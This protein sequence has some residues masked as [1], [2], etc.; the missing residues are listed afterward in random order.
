MR[1]PFHRFPFVIALAVSAAAADVDVS[2]LPPVAARTV[3]FGKDIAPIFEKNCV[4]CHGAEKQKGGL[5][6]DVKDSALNGGDNF[7][8][9]IRPGKSAESPLVHFVAGL[10]PDVKM[11]SKGDP[12]TPEQIGLL[13]AWIDQGAV[14]PEGVDKVAMADGRDHWSF[15]PVTHPEPPAT[16]DKMW[17]RNGVDYFILERLEKEG[18]KPSPEAER[19]TWLRRVSFD[20]TGLPPSP[21]Q[22]EAFLKDDRADAHERV[23]DEL[24]NSPR[25]GECWAQHWLDVV[26]YADTDGFE[27]N[28]ERPDAWPYRDYV[29]RALNEDTPYDRFIR[30]QLAGDATGVDAA[31]GFL[32]TAAALLPGQIGKDEASIRLARQDSLGEIVSATGQVFLGLSVGCARCHDHKFDPIPQRDYYAMQAFFARVQYGERPI[33][34]PQNDEA[35]AKEAGEIAAR[36]ASL[37]PRLEAAQP[38]GDNGD[39]L[40]ADAAEFARLEKRKAELDKGPMVFAGSFTTPDATL[41]LA[42]GDPEQP[43]DIVAPAVL[44]TLGTLTLPPETAG[45]ERRVALASWIASSEN[46]LTARVMVNRIWQWHFGIGLVETG[47]DFGHSG[48][49][50]SHRALLDWLAL[51]FIRSGWSVKHMHRLICT[52]AT[53]R[54]SSRMDRAAL[55]IDADCRLLWRFPARRLEAETIRDSMLAVS[56][57][58]DP[59]MGGPGFNLFTARGGLNGFPPIESFIGDGLR[60]MIYAHKVRMERDAVFGAFDCPDAGQST[61][62]RRPSTSPLQALNLFNSRFT[63]E[64]AAAFAKR[65]QTEAGADSAAQIRRA[66]RLALGREPDSGEIQDAEPIVREHGLAALCRAL[67]NSNE[68][69]FLP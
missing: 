18:L 34:D 4:K 58:L 26:R 66:C 25:Y 51:E 43:R 33:R 14:W 59:K 21:E 32:V 57:R 48:A 39:S 31:T 50:P 61:P 6:L 54:Q 10:D 9:N 19:V 30:E 44:T 49:K 12:L 45:Q 8:P 2:R 7:A 35:R 37:K 15:K 53:Y 63:I 28:T 41:L 38:P 67:F 56:G 1:A 65:V 52:S 20:V 55:A 5:R 13:R 40:K 36:I 16:L 3:D 27:V 11:P 46:P 24:L 42:R 62:R 68:F 69:L 47:S 64:E 23:V 17:P 22:V 60:R 29:I